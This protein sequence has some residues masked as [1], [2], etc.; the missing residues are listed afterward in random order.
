MTVH[1]IEQAIKRRAKHRGLNV[2]FERMRYFNSLLFDIGAG[3]QAGQTLY[4]GVGHGHDA[5]LAIA[6]HQT[7]RVIGV[8]PYISGHGNNDE[9]L[10]LLLEIIEE[11]DLIEQFTVKRMLVQEHLE[12]AGKKVDRIVCNDVLH[13]IFVTEERLTKSELFPGAV[14]LFRRFLDSVTDDGVLLVA[15]VGR[16]GLRQY[17]HRVARALG[18]ARFQGN[19]IR[20]QQWSEWDAALQEAGWRRESVRNY[21]PFSLKEH[22]SLFG[23]W[24][25][26]ATLCDKYFLTYR[27]R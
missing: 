9:D 1:P 19:Y 20:K 14:E 6:D 7:E 2:D 3:E 11:L 15:D 18:F 23:G 5:L 13:H 25:G 12:Q 16:H 4:V 17:I 22:D 24:L 21:I 8:D 10:R 26:R 27:K